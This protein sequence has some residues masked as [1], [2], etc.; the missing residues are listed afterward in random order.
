MFKASQ[1]NALPWAVYWD[2]DSRTSTIADR[3]YRPIVTAPGK[4]PKWDAAL[5]T[6]APIDAKPLYGATPLTTFYRADH[7]SAPFADPIVRRRLRHLIEGC[8]AL[9]N[10]L[11]KRERMQRETA[12]E[13]AKPEKARSHADLIRHTFSDGVAA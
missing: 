2:A 6:A 1:S 10:E 7:A 8:M 12:A 9:R 5:A 4:Y 3:C 13:D 11:R